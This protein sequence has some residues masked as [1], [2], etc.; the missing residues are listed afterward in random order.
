MLNTIRKRI[1][2]SVVGIGA[3]VGLLCAGIVY[4][5]YSNYIDESLER[6]LRIGVLGTQ[7]SFEDLTPE[8]LLKEGRANTEVYQSYIK[9]VSELAESFGFA[10]IYVLG[11][12]SGNDFRICLS[13][14]DY[15]AKPEEVGFD[16][17]YPDTPPPLTEA[18]NT[19]KMIFPPVYSDS[20]GTFKS[21]ML[22]IRDSKGQVVALLGADYDVSF[23]DGL[24]NKA[25]MWSVLA[26][27]IAMGIAV[28]ASSILSGQMSGPILKSAA[29]AGR[30]SKGET[31]KDFD[32]GDSTSQTDEINSMIQSFNSMSRVL[33][34]KMLNLQAIANGDLT[35]DIHFA[36]E[37]DELAQVIDSMK[38]SIQ[39]VVSQIQS[40]ARRLNVSADQLAQSSALAGDGASKQAASMEEINSSI[41]DISGQATANSERSETATS[42]AKTASQKAEEGNAEMENLNQSMTKIISSSEEIKKIV[43]VIDDIAF[44]TNLLALNAAVEAAR[45]GQHGKGFAV[46]AE[47][48]RNLANRSAKAA[49]ETSDMVEN[50]GKHVQS[51]QENVITTAEKLKEIL[52][53]STQVSQNLSEITDSSRNQ[54]SGI[55]QITIAMDQVS[56][57]IQSTA[58]AT[59]EN[60][61]ISQE[62][63]SEVKTIEELVSRFRL[64]QQNELPRVS[65]SAQL[66][67]HR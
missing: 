34:E 31:V 23:V 17:P 10:F 65:S 27:A 29:F 46:V 48:V 3:V 63:L 6:E 32:F 62:L 33:Q 43:K 50:S 15:K 1:L 53:A 25:M 44:Q 51:G 55:E 60:A 49:A 26:F 9:K 2:A 45:A 11:E 21:V 16:Q 12:K 37:K 52:E 8:F 19:G 13:S 61:S 30:F 66:V 5:Q 47:E 56:Q 40:V 36:S 67:T 39:A 64:K 14:A 42:A 20:Y 57:V 4:S 41:N 22:P 24:K 35:G 18:W 59:E 28:L 58:A 54:A 38:N 7:A